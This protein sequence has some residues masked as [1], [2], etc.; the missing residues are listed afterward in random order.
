MDSNTR[1]CTALLLLCA[2]SLAV[3]CN[4]FQSTPPEPPAAQ[5]VLPVAPAYLPP[6][7]AV[8]KLDCCDKVHNY[9][10][11]NLYLTLGNDA[12]AKWT[13]KV[14]KEA[15][16]VKPGKPAGGTADCV[17]KTSPEIFTKI[18]RDAYVPGPSEFL[19]G[20]IKS[21]DVSLLMTFQKVFALA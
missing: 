2:V 13:V 12:Q 3:G 9:N 19:S 8:D 18:V 21:N 7:R 17:L 14:S 4:L 5:A 1:R 10:S 15:C 16:E 6:D 20:A 11:D